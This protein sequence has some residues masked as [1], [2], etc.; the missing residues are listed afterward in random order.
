MINKKRLLIIIII[1]AVLLAVLFTSGRIYNFFNS[2]D[3]LELNFQKGISFRLEN[4][5]KDILFIN[6][7]EMIAINNR[8]EISFRAETGISDPA[9]CVSGDY[10]LITDI[11]GTNAY[12]Y[13]GDKLVNKFEM[14]NTIYCAKVNKNGR[15]VIATA[16]SGYKGMFTVFSSSGEELYKWHSGSGY[17][18]D[19]DISPKNDVVVSQIVTDENFVVS[20]ILFF[21]I[22]KNEEIE[23]AKY[24]N[25]LVSHVRFNSDSTFTALSDTG[26]SGF[27]SKCENKFFVDFQGRTLV[28]YN[29]SNM[30]NIVLAFEGSVNDIIIEA[31]SHSGKLKGSFRPDESIDCID[32]NGEMI[33]MSSGRKI[34]TYTPTGNIKMKKDI[35]H[36][37]SALKIFQG[38]KKAVLLGGSN[39]AIYNGIW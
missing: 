11:G 6:N 32:V 27:S 22:S 28:Y 33:L 15:T 5:K 9:V 25:S 14:P 21:D 16:E 2:S 37:I 10:I 34:M 17:I 8:G 19:I 13:K 1:F 7:E 36:D 4:Y 20:K 31:Y 23:C 12:L 3:M 26:M 39:A 35:S 38:R 29:T 24:D 18:A 30:N